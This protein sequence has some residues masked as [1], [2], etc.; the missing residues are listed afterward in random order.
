M[1][2]ASRVT[3]SLVLFHLIEQAY[4]ENLIGNKLNNLRSPRNKVY[5]EYLFSISLYILIKQTQINKFF[6]CRY[7]RVIYICITEL[8]KFG[9]GKKVFF[10]MDG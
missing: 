8:I 6:T 7:L 9:I 3:L 5:Q 4:Y 2:L 1:R 10:G